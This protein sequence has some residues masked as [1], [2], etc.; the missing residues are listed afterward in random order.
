MKVAPAGAGVG[1]SH[2]WGL[3][4]ALRPR[5]T[6]SQSQHNVNRGSGGETYVAS[7]HPH[8]GSRADFSYGSPAGTQEKPPG[9]VPLLRIQG[10]SPR[11]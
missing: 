4:P 6:L 3:G 11:H 10:I 7:R 5:P 2:Q 8:I 1:Q 9:C